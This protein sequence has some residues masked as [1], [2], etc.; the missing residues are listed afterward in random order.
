MDT[1]KLPHEE[2]NPTPQST[3]PQPPIPPGDMA[4]L[5]RDGMKLFIAKQPEKLVSFAQEWYQK[6]YQAGFDHGYQ[7]ALKNRKKSGDGF[8]GL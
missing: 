1:G 4:E 8:L 6:A 2:T 5:I 3:P 7:A